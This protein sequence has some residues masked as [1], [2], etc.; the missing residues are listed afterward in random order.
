MQLSG[1][2]VQLRRYSNDVAEFIDHGVDRA[3]DVV[4]DTLAKSSWLPEY[5]K[6]SPPPPPPVAIVALSRFEQLQDWISRHKILTGVIVVACGTVAFKGY[7]RSR[8]LKK[9][10]RAK[11]AKNGGRTEVVVIAG[12]PTLPLTK[13]LSLDLERRGFVV[14]IV[15]NATEDE[16][17]V[18]AYARPDIRPLSIDTTDVGLLPYTLIYSMLISVFSPLAPALPS[19]GSRDICKPLRPPART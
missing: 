12:S 13:S 14:Y 11:R 16:S 1:I 7:Q 19:N 8:W 6:P 3:A 2:P 5:A 18:H 9:T 15:C 4:R 10:R 17:I